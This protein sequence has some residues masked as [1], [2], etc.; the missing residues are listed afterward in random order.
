MKF[1]CYYE[2]DHKYVYSFNNNFNSEYYDNDPFIIEL[3]EYLLNESPQELRVGKVQLLC[4]TNNCGVNNDARGVRSLDWKL[5]YWNKY[6]VSRNEG[7]T[8]D[9]LIIASYK[10]R[11]HKFENNYELFTGIKKAAY[12]NGVLYGL[13][14]FDHG[15]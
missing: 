3:H 12:G 5:H 10:I 7:I 11:S 1:T 2:K 14:R 15:S 9:D 8:L 6:D 4:L 13:C